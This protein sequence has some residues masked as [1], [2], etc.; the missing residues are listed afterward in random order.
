MVCVVREVSE[1]R[2]IFRGFYFLSLTKRNCEV[3][4]LVVCKLF[5]IGVRD[6]LILLSG[7]FAIC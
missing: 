4:V 5:M 3:M 2:M 6:T 1:G 7:D